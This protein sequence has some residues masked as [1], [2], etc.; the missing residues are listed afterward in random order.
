MDWRTACCGG[1]YAFDFF[2]ILGTKR[3]LRPG[4]GGGGVQ[5]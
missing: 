4:V 2:C 3:L 1:I 5:F